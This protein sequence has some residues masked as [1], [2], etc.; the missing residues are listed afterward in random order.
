[1]CRIW[2]NLE[3]GQPAQKT[4]DTRF[5]SL[6]KMPTQKSGEILYGQSLR[7]IFFFVISL[8]Y[9]ASAIC[10]PEYSEGNFT[11]WHAYAVMLS[12]DAIRTVN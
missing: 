1:M 8:V 12:K 9:A 11:A 5:F 4:L 10:S 2:L 3:G 7:D 6:M